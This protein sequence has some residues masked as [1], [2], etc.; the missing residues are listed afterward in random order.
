VQPHPLVHDS[1]GPETSVATTSPRAAPKP[2]LK[3]TLTHLTDAI[4]H[5]ITLLGLGLGCWAAHGLSVWLEDQGIEPWAGWIVRGVAAI[6][7]VQ[8][9]CVCLLFL[10][11]DLLDRVKEFRG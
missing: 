11:R 9:A 7:L 2:R 6:M 10:G 8:E 4:L 1:R 5:L 3:R